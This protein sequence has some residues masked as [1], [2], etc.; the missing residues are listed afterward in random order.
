MSEAA[1]ACADGLTRAQR[2]RCPHCGTGRLRFVLRIWPRPEH[3]CFAAAAM[4]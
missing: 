3:V 4:R 2:L 1:G